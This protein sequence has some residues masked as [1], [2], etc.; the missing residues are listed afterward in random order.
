MHRVWLRSEKTPH[1][2]IGDVREEMLLCLLPFQKLN[3]FG[4]L[5]VSVFA[6]VLALS[7]ET[8]RL[9]YSNLELRDVSLQS[10]GFYS[11]SANLTLMGSTQHYL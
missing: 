6:L 9:L 3:T 1:C 11:I 4:L 10:H 7:P 5:L 2:W 8:P